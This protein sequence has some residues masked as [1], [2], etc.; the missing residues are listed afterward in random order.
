MLAGHRNSFA[1]EAELIEIYGKWIYGKLRFWVA[2]ASIGDFDDT[3]DLA[4]SARWGRVFLAASPGRP[5]P[6][7]DGVA[8]PDVYEVLC[9]EF[10]VDST[11][12]PEA[13]ARGGRAGSVW[14][15]EP[16]L[17]DDVGESSLR[18]KYAILVVRCSD[19]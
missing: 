10:V 18:D 13:P 2:G 8:G 19:G 4:T 14:D 11:P 12:R 7:R 15:R 17:L 6:A 1:I 9:G 16:Y 3:S 5:R